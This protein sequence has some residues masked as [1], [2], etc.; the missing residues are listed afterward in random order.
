[1]IGRLM[2]GRLG[3]RNPTPGTTFAGK[4]VEVGRAVTRFQ[5]GDEVFGS[6]GNGAHAE[7]LVVAEESPVS[8]T[9]PWG[10]MIR[11]STTMRLRRFTRGFDCHGTSNCSEK[12]WG[13][14]WRA[15]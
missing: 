10:G 15:M 2:F 12:L 6:C 8:S 5:V 3:P 7:Y 11:S 14:L 13:R 4:V 1:M 9:S